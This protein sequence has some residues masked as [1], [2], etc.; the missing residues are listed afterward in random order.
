FKSYHRLATNIMREFGYGSRIMESRIQLELEKLIENFK[1]FEGKEFNPSDLTT[2]CSMNI[3]CSI[4]FGERYDESDPDLSELIALVHNTFRNFRIAFFLQVLKFLIH[5]PYFKSFVQNSM[6][7]RT[8]ILEIV[9]E[10][11]K[12][13]T[14]PLYRQEKP[15]FIDRYIEM[16]GPV[17]DRP[18]LLHLIHDL[19]LAGT[20]TTASMLQWA[21]IIMANNISIQEKMRDE[22]RRVVPHDRLPSLNDKPNLI[23]FEASVLELIRF[24]SAAPTS[25][26]HTTISDC[27]ISGYFIPADTFVLGNIYC[28]HFNPKI[29]EE[30][31]VFRPERF[32]KD[33]Q[34]IN[35]DLLVP[36]SIGKRSCFGE[37]LARQ[38]MF[39][40]VSSLVQK[41]KILPPGD[42]RELIVD[43]IYDVTLKP[44]SFNI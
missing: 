18:Q 4:L 42:E 28:A 44:A 33:G 19:L 14:D 20:E 43:E 9:E 22:L 17:N 16:E 3:M 7:M 35:K 5:V 34:I 25:V 2:I 8:R 21:L 41:F 24:K 13:C 37:I 31:D 15:N 11:A 26:P 32:I 27:E 29:W 40:F 10:K 36:F 23:Y 1:K 30:P 12:T 6:Q 39:L 38:E